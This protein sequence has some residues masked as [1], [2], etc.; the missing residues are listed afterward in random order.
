MRM[1]IQR[2]KLQ[3]LRL[4]P[5]SG[6][7]T[8]TKVKYYR[9]YHATAAGD[10]DSI[11]PVLHPSMPLEFHELIT[12]KLPHIP[13]ADPRLGI[14][15]PGMVD[16]YLV[17]PSAIVSSKANPNQH[18]I[19]SNAHAFTD[20]RLP[21][22]SNVFY[23]AG[24][25]RKPDFVYNPKDPNRFAASSWDFNYIR[26]VAVG[27]ASVW[28]QVGPY[29][30]DAMLATIVPNIPCEFAIPEIGLITGVT[31]PT[32]GMNLVGRGVSSGVR[33]GKV[34]K[35]NT[36]GNLFHQGTGITEKVTGAFEVS[37]PASPGDSGTLYLEQGTNKAVGLHFHILNGKNLCCRA[38]AIEAALGVDFKGKPGTWQ[39]GNLLT[40]TRS[41]EMVETLVRNPSLAQTA[42][43]AVQRAVDVL[44]GII[45]IGPLT[46]NPTPIPI[47][48]PETTP[49]YTAPSSPT[50][51]PTT[52]LSGIDFANISPTTLGAIAIGGVLLLAIL[53]K[54]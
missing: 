37:V 43:A 1:P 54:K 14:P 46:A 21:P 30:V 39:N 28:K 38:S 42:D 12:K 52:G 35:V 50:I 24:G 33:T 6:L 16:V 22:S 51:I 20:P 15:S 7:G 13:I 8:G 3:R 34:T 31:E 49:K 36:G 32:L 5:I 29:Y 23:Q 2:Q 4:Q 40:P 10:V 41:G 19:M 44:A 45:P 48:I 47:P 11:H 27:Y 26:K 17:T 53:L 9:S 25:I 18:F